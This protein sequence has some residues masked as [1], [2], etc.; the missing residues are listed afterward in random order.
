MIQ[1]L[2]PC[3]T[4]ARAALILRE[5]F[6]SLGRPFAFQ[7]WDGTEVRFGSDAPVAT[8]VIKA[9]AT[10]VAL[11]RDPSPGNFAEAYV[12]SD[13]DLEGD[14]FAAMDVANAIEGIRLSP[15]QKLRLFLSMW[16]P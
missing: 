6:G 16:R 10:F 2:A 8:A 3:P 9:P 13:I 5:V 1:L 15:M 11:M 14:L 4:P 7:L 12:A